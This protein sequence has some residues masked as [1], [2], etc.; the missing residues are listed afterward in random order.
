MSIKTI[1]NSI[2]G[3]PSWFVGMKVELRDRQGNT[4]QGRVVKD[5]AEDSRYKEVT[6]HMNNR[7][8]NSGKGYFGVEIDDR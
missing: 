5:Y 7:T 3:F 8:F 2:A 4:F 1:F 6:D